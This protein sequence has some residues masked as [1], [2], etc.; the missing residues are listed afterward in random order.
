MFKRF[1][2]NTQIFI[3]IVLLYRILLDYTYIYIIAPTYGYARLSYDP[4]SIGA[5][6][7]WVALILGIYLIL[8][9]RKMDGNI[10]PQ[11]MI[12]MFFYSYVPMTS[13]WSCSS[14]PLDFM[15]SCILFWSLWFVMMRIVKAP[16]FSSI[17]S[18]N[19]RAIYA[20]AIFFA[21]SVFII[22]GVYAN[23][24][25]HLSLTD[26]YDMRLEAR[27]FDMPIFL[28]YI[29]AASGNVIPICMIYFLSIKNNKMV[30]LL[31]IATLFNFSTNGSKSSLFKMLLC[32]GLYYYGVK[33]YK[34]SLSWLFVILLVFCV[35]EFLL[36]HSSGIADVLIRRS[37]YIP[38]LLDSLFFDYISISEPTYYSS[39]GNDITFR[40]GDIY[41]DKS[42]MRC[43]NGLYT[44]AFVN[45][46]WI[47]LFIYP[48]VFSLFFKVCENCFKFANPQICLFAAFI[49]AT[50]FR[51]SLF[52]TSLLTH[53][54]FLTCITVAFM[55][56][57]YNENENM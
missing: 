1:L 42:E 22:S 56:Q 52:T 21:I 2:D 39:E 26:V 7:S 51:S 36:L 3:V 5:L 47:G 35:L 14:L 24:R 18:P 19:P 53:G 23:F 13:Y 10:V 27:D 57:I 30:C 15:G 41:F 17:V 45:L 16:D 34:R 49:S 28:K 9:F 32:I 11:T 12:L 6:F 31:A 50:T 48:I 38:N 4:S 33:D 25:I 29:W 8:P 44:D 55:P 46:G 20:I 43:N 54:I 37:M 40:I